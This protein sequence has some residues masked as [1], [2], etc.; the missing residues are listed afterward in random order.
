[1]L[2]AWGQVLCVQVG[3]FFGAIGSSERDGDLQSSMHR[4]SAARLYTCVST[5]GVLG[6]LTAEAV[7]T[8][9]PSSARAFGSA[10][11]VWWHPAATACGETACFSRRL[12]A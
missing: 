10:A 7:E 4:A 12:S 11:W 2:H 6:A 8:G 5:G 3:G 9:R 1:M